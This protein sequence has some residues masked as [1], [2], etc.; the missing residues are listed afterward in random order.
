MGLPR[1]GH[2]PWEE[3]VSMGEEAASQLPSSLGG[4]HCH[5]GQAPLRTAWE[6]S[7]LL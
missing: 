5:G 6:S 2:C 1:A 3:Q 7:F 4:P